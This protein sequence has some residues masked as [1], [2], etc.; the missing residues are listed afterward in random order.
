M[1]S[2]NENKIVLLGEPLLELTPI[3]GQSY[4]MGV[5]GDVLNVAVVVSHLYGEAHLLAALGLDSGS[6]KILQFARDHDVNTEAVVID[7]AH[8]AGMYFIN[9]DA[10]GE[11]TFT[12][13][14]DNSAAK[15]FFG[16]SDQL[17]TALNK[18]EA[19]SH[20]YFSGITLALMTEASRTAFVAWLDNFRRSG[21]LVVFDNNYRPALW[22]SADAYLKAC[23]WVLSRTDIFLPSLDDVMLSLGLVDKPAAMAWIVARDVPEVV[24]SDGVQPL[25][26]MVNGTTELIDV[27]AANQVADTTGAG[28]GF[29]GGYLAARLSGASAQDAVKC[30]MQLAADVVGHK[31]AILPEEYWAKV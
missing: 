21:G 14:R 10:L 15:H 13:K 9:N 25:T 2:Q 20:I 30:G 16:D 11:R 4:N 3:S 19:V 31:G 27:I 5:A 1:K 17:L 7:H 24:V 6:D 28:D 26:L 23:E 22:P 8:K 12:Y 18:L 29:N